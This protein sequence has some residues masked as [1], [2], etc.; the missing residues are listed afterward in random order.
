MPEEFDKVIVQIQSYL[1]IRKRSYDNSFTA[2]ETDGDKPVT[3]KV[4]LFGL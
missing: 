1:L 3:E 2:F 4:C